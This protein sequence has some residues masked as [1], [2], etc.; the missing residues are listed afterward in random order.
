[1]YIGEKPELRKTVVVKNKKTT[2]I[3]MAGHLKSHL[4]EVGCAVD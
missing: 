2:K 4:S 1:V 3:M